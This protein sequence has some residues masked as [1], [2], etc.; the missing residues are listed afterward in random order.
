MGRGNKRGKGSVGLIVKG[1]C[2]RL[3][4]GEGQTDSWLAREEKVQFK[5]AAS[6]P[7]GAFPVLVR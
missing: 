2:S 6:N 7:G 5:E 3:G 1:D 4:L